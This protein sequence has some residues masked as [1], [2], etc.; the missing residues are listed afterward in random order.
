MY[1]GIEI[2]ISDDI[3]YL[4]SKDPLKLDVFGKSG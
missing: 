1:A 3:N 4:S 2:R